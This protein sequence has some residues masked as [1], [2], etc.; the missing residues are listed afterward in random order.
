MNTGESQRMASCKP[1]GRE[2]GE[3]EEIKVLTRGCRW[4]Q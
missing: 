1:L 2:S 3:Q 4:Q